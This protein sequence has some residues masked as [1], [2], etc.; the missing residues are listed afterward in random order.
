[1]SGLPPLLNAFYDDGHRCQGWINPAGDGIEPPPTF[2]LRGPN[3]WDLDPRFVPRL[4]QSGLLP[5]A[6]MTSTGQSLMLDS[7]LLTALVDR[8]RPETHTFHFRWGEMTPTLKDVAM[9][10]GLPLRGPPVVPQPESLTWREDLEARFGI[11]LPRKEGAKEIRGVPKSWLSQFTVVP[12]DADDYVIR[13]HLIAYLLFLFGSIMFPSSSG[14]TIPP[15]YINMAVEIADNQFDDIIA[16]SWGSAVLCHTYRGLCVAVQKK[17]IRKEP[18]LSV[19]YIL[20]QLWSWEHLPIGR[21]QIEHPVHPY[22]L[23]D[24]RFEPATFGSRWTY[25][26]LRWARQFAG[27]CYP[28][29]HDDLERLH[30]TEVIWDP[31]SQEDILYVGGAPGLSMQCTCDADIWMTRCNLVFAYMVEP[32]QPERVMRQFGLFQEV[33]PPPPRELAH[34]VHTQRNQGKSRH[35][36]RHTN[37]AWIQNWSDAST[38]TVDEARAYDSQTY[39]AYV[40]WYSLS[41]RV[42][43]TKAPPQRPTELTRD[44]QRERGMD[45]AVAG[46]RDDTI[47]RA[48]SIIFD[49]QDIIRENPAIRHQL[50]TMLKSILDNAKGIVANWSCGRVDDVYLGAYHMPEVRSARPSEERSSRPSDVEFTCTTSMRHEV[51]ARFR[52]VIYPNFMYVHYIMILQTGARLDSK[53]LRTAPRSR[54]PLQNV[55][56]GLG[57]TREESPPHNTARETRAQSS[58][59]RGQGSQIQMEFTPAAG[60]ENWDHLD[61]SDARNLNFPIQRSMYAGQQH[62]LSQLFQGYSN[63]AQSSQAI[64]TSSYPPPQP[65]QPTDVDRDISRILIPQA[66]ER[67]RETPERH[68]YPNPRAKSPLTYSA[69]HC[70]RKKKKRRRKVQE[71]EA[72]PNDSATVCL[73]LPHV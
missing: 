26:K 46:R 9:I 22:K 41:T 8:W 72:E 5:L 16:Y 30:D 48:N 33:P 3:K 67:P 12:P 70:A 58:C 31:F 38:N 14:D 59:D 4:A 23:G 66:P 56:L 6:R 27:K 47:D 37:H 28:L 34:D 42:R 68:L 39:E 69:D 11:P 64:D 20:L 35:D 7:S 73:A 17:P 45:R 61:G 62:V 54:S 71:A 10:T 2:R 21:P 52:G 19:C 55:Q 57:P 50:K 63:G 13:K 18:V 44:E 1:M 36:W 60:D 49:A 53:L 40:Q 24:T 32:Y 29:Y 15:S 65:T 51:H 43:L 25:G